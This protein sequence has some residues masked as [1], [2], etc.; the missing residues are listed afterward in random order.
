MLHLSAQSSNAA[1]AAKVADPAEEVSEA[2]GNNRRA[3]FICYRL[4]PAQGPVL[5]LLVMGERLQSTVSPAAAPP[6]CRRRTISS[7]GDER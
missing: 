4:V 5:A 6:L 2:G 3:F 7:L 1:T